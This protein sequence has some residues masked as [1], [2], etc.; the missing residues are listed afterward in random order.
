VPAIATDGISDCLPG[1]FGAVASA[2]KDDS[3]SKN[4]K[5]GHASGF[6]FSGHGIHLLDVTPLRLVQT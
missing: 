3:G 2:S 4:E 6:C 1:L 5:Q